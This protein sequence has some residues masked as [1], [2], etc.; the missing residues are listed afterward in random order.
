MHQRGGP[1]LLCPFFSMLGGI[2][3]GTMHPAR[4]GLIQVKVAVTCHAFQERNVT[5]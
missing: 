2:K 1:S 5:F 3:Q 4:L